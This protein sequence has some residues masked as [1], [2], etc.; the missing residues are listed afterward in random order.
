MTKL[1]D[2]IRRFNQHVKKVS[3]GATTNLWEMYHQALDHAPTPLDYNVIQN[4][5]LIE[6]FE[7]YGHTK[8]KSDEK[9]SIRQVELS[10][11]WNYDLKEIKSIVENWKKARTR[12]AKKEDWAKMH[13]ICGRTLD[14]YINFIETLET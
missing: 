3:P 13:N 5:N 10:G 6:L 12:G 1:T 14:N 8:H 7:F 4:W 2:R 11:H 9:N